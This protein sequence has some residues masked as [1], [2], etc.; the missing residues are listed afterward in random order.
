MISSIIR[1]AMRRKPC[2]SSEL[3]IR[4]W[5]ET[6]ATYNDNIFGTQTNSKGAFLF[7]VKPAFT[8]KSDWSRHALRFEA[9]V[10]VGRYTSFTSENYVD[11]L[12]GAGGRYDIGPDTRIDVGT[13]VQQFHESGANPEAPTDRAEASVYRAYNANVTAAHKFA[14]VN[15]SAGADT[16]Y[17]DYDPV[18][19]QSGTTDSQSNRNRWENNYTGRVGF[20]VQRGFETFLRGTY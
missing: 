20:E 18:L 13:R 1:A 17:F 14:R 8:A 15:L 12:T 7:D 16:T 6:D 10:D 2:P 19:L 4:G 5:Y 11:F 3:I 9:S